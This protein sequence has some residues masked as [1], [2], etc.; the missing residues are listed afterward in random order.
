MS[1]LW[2]KVQT[3]LCHFTCSGFVLCSYLVVEVKPNDTALINP[4]TELLVSPY[5]LYLTGLTV[6]RALWYFWKKAFSWDTE[7]QANLKNISFFSLV[8]FN[9]FFFSQKSS[10]WNTQLWDNLCLKENPR[11]VVLNVLLYDR[12][13]LIHQLHTMQLISYR[14]SLTVFSHGTLIWYL[15]FHILKCI[16]S[17]KVSLNDTE[18]FPGWARNVNSGVWLLKF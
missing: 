5:C 8:N 17:D 16:S 12:G 2:E 4:Y 14:S 11:M 9:F 10:K 18:C 1:H 7:K 13:D 3:C 15:G 6:L